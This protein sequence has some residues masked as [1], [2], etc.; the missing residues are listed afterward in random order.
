[1][2]THVHVDATTN[3]KDPLRPGCCRQVNFS[4]LKVSI[5]NYEYSLVEPRFWLKLVSHWLSCAAWAMRLPTQI[6]FLQPCCSPNDAVS[7]D[8]VSLSDVALHGICLKFW[9]HCNIIIFTAQYLYQLPFKMTSR[10]ESHGRSLT[11]WIYLMY[12]VNKRSDCSV[13][14]LKLEPY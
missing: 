7:R 1:M 8:A 3:A 6:L 14:R 9:T 2:Q 5:W 11:D 4:W 13:Y 12:S 10:G